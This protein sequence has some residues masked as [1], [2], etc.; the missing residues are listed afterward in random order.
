ME[1]VKDLEKDLANTGFYA[2]LL[3]GFSLSYQGRPLSL[4]ANPQAGYM[5]ILICLLKA[6][7]AG[8]DRKKLLDINQPEGKDEKQRSNNFRQQVHMLRNA[9]AGADFPEGRY[10][11][12]YRSR[13]Y[14]TREYEVQTDTQVLDEII[15]QLRTGSLNQEERRN[16]YLAYCKSYT[17]EFLPL[18]NGEEWATVESAYYQKW[19]STCLQELCTILREEEDYELLLRLSTSASQIHPYDEWQAVQID[20][21]MMLN[22]RK[23]A[24]KVYAEASEVY[25]RDL[26]MNSLDRVMTRYQENSQFYHMGRAMNRMKNNLEEYG[27]AKGAYRCSYPSF[28]DIYRIRA[29]L[30]EQSNEPNLLLLCTL[31]GKPPSEGEWEEEGRAE[32]MELF[33]K[34]LHHGTRSEDV[35]TQYSQSQYLVLLAGADRGTGNLVASRLKAIWKKSGGQAKV[36]FSLSELESPERVSKETRETREKREGPA[37]PGGQYEK[38]G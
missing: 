31:D 32:Q 4:N 18:L 10:V 9:I 14:F 16:A 34:V 13:Y 17:G 29:R 22:R 20:C 6:G 19:Y 12:V 37:E 33:Q 27:R 38:T 30:G 21:L 15:T 36:E 3:G 35:Y 11:V 1:T 24:E 8:M 25:Y 23:E 28:V 2:R 26:G 7:K 5:Q